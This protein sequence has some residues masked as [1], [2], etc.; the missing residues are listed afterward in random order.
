MTKRRNFVYLGV[1]L[2]AAL[3][4]FGCGGNDGGL[5]SEDMAR[6]DAAEMTAAEAKTALAALQAQIDADTADTTDPAAPDADTSD[7]AA[8][9]AELEALLAKL[10]AKP[11]TIPETLSGEK[12][13]LTVADIAAASKKVAGQ[14]NKLYDHDGDKSLVNLGELVDPAPG[15]GNNVTPTPDKDAVTRNVTHASQLDLDDDGDSEFLKH[16]FTGT[17]TEVDL[18]SMGD[19]DTLT[20][21]R[22]LKVDGVELMSFS[23]KETDKINTVGTTGPASSQLI[24]GE[25]THMTTTTLGA[26]GSKMA[27]TTNDGSGVVTSSETTVYQGG[28]KIVENAS[29]GAVVTLANGKVTTYVVSTNPAGTW[30]ATTTTPALEAR[31]L[32]SAGP[33]DGQERLRG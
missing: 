30:T 22:L 5:S 9:I 27:I 28:N 10:T 17:G 16:T 8:Q 19:V 14:L 33:C 32:P 21:G 15:N 20:L 6:I 4:A 25:T 2:A 18:S 7:L 11:P 12:S 1:L 26:D 24:M 31:V 29:G 23:V 13:K 3:F